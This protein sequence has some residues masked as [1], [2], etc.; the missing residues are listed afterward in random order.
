MV[1]NGGDMDGVF[2]EFHESIGSTNTR[3]K[4]LARAGAAHAST[5]VAARQ[6]GGRGRQGRPFSS[7]CGSGVYFSV[8]LRSAAPLDAGLLSARAALAVCEACEALAADAGARAECLV[9]W[10]ND[11]YCREK[12]LAGILIEGGHDAGGSGGANGGDADGE[13]G[14]WYYVVGIGINVYEPRG[15]WPPELARAGALL[16]RGQANSGA[17]EADGGCENAD[18]ANG[19]GIADAAGGGGIAHA[20]EFLVGRIRAQLADAPSPASDNAALLQAYRTR[21]MLTGRTI[22]VECGGAHFTAMVDGIDDDFSLR[23]REGGKTRH[24]RCGEVHLHLG[25]MDEKTAR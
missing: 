18:D 20:R 9:K 11:V 8:L 7:P 22:E 12:K 10:P 13:A 1:A 6:T 17:G 25:G 23:V 5:V 19:G 15:G 14:G 16:E 21:S 4:E 2:V 24:L 3:C